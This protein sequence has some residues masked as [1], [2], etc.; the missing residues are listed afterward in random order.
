MSSSGIPGLGSQAEVALQRGQIDD[1]L[2]SLSRSR[3]EN[4]VSDIDSAVRLAIQQSTL[5]GSAEP[6]MVALRSADDILTEVFHYT[7]VDGGGL[8]SSSTLTVTITGAND[9]PV[10]TVKDGD[11]AAEGVSESDLTLTTSG[12]LSV[13]DVDL[14][15]SV[16]ASVVSV[17]AGGT[18]SGLGADPA[19]LRSM[20]NVDVGQVID[21]S[22]T[23]GTM[24]ACASASSSSVAPVARRKRAARC[25]S[26]Q[27]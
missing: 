2:Q 1:L 26:G 4:A 18:T 10:I 20:L 22:H 14:L 13:E 25:A 17:V 27:D 9:A 3:D 23:T 6:L 8:T 24:P 5:T 12:T 19:T 21:A 11:S 7:M 15:D 16:T